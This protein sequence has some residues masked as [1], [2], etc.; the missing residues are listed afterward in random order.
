MEKCDESGDVEVEVVD[1]DEMGE[2]VGEQDGEE[3]VDV[4]VEVLVS[5]L[6]LEEDDRFVAVFLDRLALALPY[7]HC[8]SL[9]DD[10]TT[11]LVLLAPALVLVVADND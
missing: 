9:D 6:G 11:V 3:D 8:H 1:D 4:E 10:D 5:L 2:V 7:S